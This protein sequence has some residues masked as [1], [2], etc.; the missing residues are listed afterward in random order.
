MLLCWGLSN[1]SCQMRSAMPTTWG[2]PEIKLSNAL[3]CWSWCQTH[4]LL[5]III[6]II[7]NSS[8]V[9]AAIAI[10]ITL[11]LESEFL[12]GRGFECFIPSYHLD[13]RRV[14]ALLNKLLTIWGRLYLGSEWHHLAVPY[15]T[16]TH[17]PL[18]CFCCFSASLLSPL[19]YL[20]GSALWAQPSA[21]E[22]CL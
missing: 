16:A 19:S 6:P 7:V 22:A 5:T 2:C 11:L 4:E 9:F 8:Y 12:A 20:C 21:S 17:L 14:F 3:K 1:L 13:S 15:Y 18:D 10:I